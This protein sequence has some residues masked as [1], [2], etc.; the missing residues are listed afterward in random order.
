[1]DPSRGFST[2]ASQQAARLATSH[3]AN[4]SRHCPPHFAFPTLPRETLET[5]LGCIFFHQTCGVSKVCCH[6]LWKDMRCIVGG[7][8]RLLIVLSSVP[9]SPPP[10]PRHSEVITTPPCQPFPHHPGLGALFYLPH[11]GFAA[12]VV[13]LLLLLLLLLICCDSILLQQC[14]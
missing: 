14:V 6:G 11:L 9:V 8:G 1:M 5:W 12:S 4:S 10:P 2:C 7:G 3:G 13:V